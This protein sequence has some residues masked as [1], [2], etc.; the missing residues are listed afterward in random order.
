MA[1]EVQIKLEEH[2][3]DDISEYL[4]PMRDPQ[5]QNIAE[6]LTPVQPSQQQNNDEYVQ[7][8]RHPQSCDRE[9]ER[10]ND[11]LQLQQNRKSWCTFQRKITSVVVLFLVVLLGTIA[12]AIFAIHNGK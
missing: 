8:V 2:T 12:V 11:N 4:E 6:Y 7:P 3:Y 10:A 1:D 5:Q 9:A